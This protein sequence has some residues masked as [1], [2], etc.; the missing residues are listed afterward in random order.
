MAFSTQVVLILL[1]LVLRLLLTPNC[2]AC[3][4]KMDSIGLV[5]IICLT[6]P[7][8]LGTLLLISSD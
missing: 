5:V 3:L 1:T 4:M 8:E 2:I 7:F 6:F